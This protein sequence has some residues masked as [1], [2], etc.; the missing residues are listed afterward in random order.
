[1]FYFLHCHLFKKI[2]SFFIYATNFLISMPKRRPQVFNLV[3]YFIPRFKTSYC[4]GL[5]WITISNN[6]RYEYNTFFKHF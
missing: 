4:T 1:M 3:Y 2:N 6:D 5:R